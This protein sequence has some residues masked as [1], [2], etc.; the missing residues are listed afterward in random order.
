M[1]YLLGK[2]DW[3]LREDNKSL[4]LESR[5][6]D[7]GFDFEA[8][9][10]S[11][12]RYDRSS[13][14]YNSESGILCSVLG[15]L[16]NIGEIAKRISMDNSTDTEI[17]EALYRSSGLKLLNELE[18]HYVIVIYDSS[19]RR[20]LVLQPEHGSFL[21][22]YYATTGEGITFSTSLKLLLKKSKVSRNIDVSAAHRFLFRRYLIPDESTLIKGVEKLVP[23]RYLLINGKERTVSAPPFIAEGQRISAGEAEENWIDYISN[24]MAEVNST[25]TDSPPAVSLSGGFD[26]NLIL[27]LLQRITDKPLVAATVNGGEGFNE[28]PR[29]KSILKNYD[30]VE[31]HTADMSEEAIDNLPDIVWRYESYLFE[32]GIF[33]RYRICNLLRN[34]GKKTALFGAGANEI[35]TQERN[36][37]FFR[38]IDNT[39]SALIN[40][41]KRGLPGRIYYSLLTGRK[42]PYDLL[43]RQFMGSARRV[44]YNSTFDLLLKMHDILLNSFGLQGIYPFVNRQTISAALALRNRNLHKELHNRKVREMLGRE[45][46][47]KIEMSDI[48][49]D[50]AGLFRFKK[51]VLMRVLDSNTALELLTPAQISTLKEDPVTY[52]I[53]MLQLVYIH[54]FTRLITSGDFDD[55]FNAPG[56]DIKLEDSL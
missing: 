12:S 38:K 8:A 35:I 50:T 24:N 54:L 47:D 22:V 43:T 53:F 49:S 6:R 44:K 27:H 48:V 42:T 46:A 45:K 28:V 31:L 15:Y 2:F 55:Y 10:M 1:N 14:F 41:L 29:V 4:T 17:V 30:G 21:P 40:Y 39:R 34:T 19:E 23:Q 11:Y 18:G 13:L 33:L 20:C 5:F 32:G 51:N 25:L 56:L 36:S 26:S 3:K 7:A 52:H 9:R 37:V 16:S